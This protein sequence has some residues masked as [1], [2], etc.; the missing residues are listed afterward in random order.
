MHQPSYTK[1]LE[2]LIYPPPV[3]HK[4]L[5]TWKP[6]NP[7]NPEYLFALELIQKIHSFNYCA[8]L[9][10][11]CVRDFLI[12]VEPSDF[13]I[14]STMPPD[15]MMEKLKSKNVKTVPTGIDH[16]T[17][18]VVKG[19]LAVEITCLRQDVQTDG[20]RAVV[21]FS[22]SFYADSLRRDFT[23]NA[24][25]LSGD[26][27]LLDFHGGLKDLQEWQLRFV[28]DPDE[29]MKEDHLR[30]LRFFRFQAK[31]GFS[32]NHCELNSVTENSPLLHSLSKE[33]VTAEIELLLTNLVNKDLFKKMVQSKLFNHINLDLSLLGIY[34]QDFENNTTEFLE[35]Q[36]ILNSPDTRAGLF[37]KKVW[38]L[39][40]FFHK[41]CKDRDEVQQKWD[42]LTISRRSR[43][44]ILCLFD[45][46]RTFQEKKTV[47]PYG[48][49]HIHKELIDSF[50]GYSQS[51]WSG[52]KI[53]IEKLASLKMNYNHV[54]TLVAD[55]GT[56]HFIKRLEINASTLMSE[57]GVP[58][59][60]LLGEILEILTQLELNFGIKDKNQIKKI[61]DRYLNAS[62]QN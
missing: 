47:L 39:S 42:S 19:K 14:A 25:Y 8:L 50:Q 53:F 21:S 45:I 48:M 28:G 60:P 43:R 23:V 49:F 5:G 11:G 10:G 59:G 33:R 27:K 58:K 44:K 26:Q 2:K 3:D 55:L 1:E 29:R 17:I 56:R 51:Q 7:E 9:A 30:I 38:S 16:G 12:G 61:V 35:F 32:V 52:V 54:R 34:N 15:Q 4:P 22:D 13:D 20:R 6:F 46:W 18:T 31:Y 40:F 36:K 41:Y 37:D 62:T 57:F 24:M